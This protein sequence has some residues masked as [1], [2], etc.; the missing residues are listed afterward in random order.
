LTIKNK[1]Q[2]LCQSSNVGELIEMILIKTFQA[3]LRTFDD[4]GN[5]K[6]IIAAR[7]AAV[8]DLAT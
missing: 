6:W 2:K 1:T 8:A 5:G 7:E 4:S 3:S